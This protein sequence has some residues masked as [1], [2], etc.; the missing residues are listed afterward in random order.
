MP[1]YKDNQIFK[2]YMSKIYFLVIELAF[3][4]K[5]LGLN[6][7]HAMIELLIDFM[8]CLQGVVLSPRMA[9]RKDFAII[10]GRS[11]KILLAC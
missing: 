3:N 10:Q 5:A 8:P 1:N 4:V 11:H 6:S 2:A 7:E 9:A